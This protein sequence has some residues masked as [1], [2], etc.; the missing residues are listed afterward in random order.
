MKIL[1]FKLKKSRAEGY[2]TLLSILII[3]SVGVVITTSLI[4][5]SIGSAR[6]S[7]ALEQANQAKG[8]ANACTEEAVQQIQ[9]DV[10]FTGSETLTIGQGECTYTVTSGGGGFRDITAVSTVGTITRKVEVSIDAISPSINIV[11]WQEVS[12]L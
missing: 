4:L 9:D 11:S 5:L 10:P 6:T 2:I 3:G 7:F 8:L 12:D 1:N